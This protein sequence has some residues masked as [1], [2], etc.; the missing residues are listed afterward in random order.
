V[1]VRNPALLL[2]ALAV[3]VGIGAVVVGLSGHGNAASASRPTPASGGTSPSS[4]SS[5]PSA[6]PSGSASPSPTG[7]AAEEIP[8]SFPHSGPGAWRYSQTQGAVLGSAGSVRTFRLAVESN[9][10]T[11]DLDAVAAKIDQ[12]LGDPRSWIAGGKVRFQRVPATAPATFTIYLATA[13]TTRSMC[14]SG[15]V[16]GTGGYTSC[17]YTGH[18]VLNLDRWYLS[19]PHYANAGVGLDVYRTYMINHEVGH[20]VGNGHER[21]PGAG[22]PAPVMEQ[23]TLGLHGCTPNPWPYV[24]GRLYRGPAGHY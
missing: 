15:G 1:R 6:S 4:P 10:S 24:D 8:A 16:T 12:T 22:M 9:V 23:Q 21:C 18:V 13:Q 2:S 11:I 5:A 17:R 14:N 19:I 3:V 7:P 20:Q